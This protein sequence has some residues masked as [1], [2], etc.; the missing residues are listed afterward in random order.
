MQQSDRIFCIRDNE[1]ETQVAIIYIAGNFADGIKVWESSYDSVYSITALLTDEYGDTEEKTVKNYGSRNKSDVMVGKYA[2]K[3][4]LG[5]I[6]F[7]NTGEPKNIKLPSCGYYTTLSDGNGLVL[8]GTSQTQ[9]S[10]EVFALM[11]V[12]LA[13]ITLEWD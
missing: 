2:V 1:K 4:E 5:E 12:I 11:D 9:E 10:T 6:W 7:R 13:S 3:E 8:I